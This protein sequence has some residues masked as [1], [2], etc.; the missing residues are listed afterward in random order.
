MSMIFSAEFVR[1]MGPVAREILG[2]PTEEN[3]AKCELRYGTRGSL[4]IDLKKGTFFDNETGDGGG[5]LKFVQVQKHLD[6]DGALAWLQEHRHIT[7]TESERQ[8]AAYDYQAA[9]G[10]LLFQVV[11]F[12]PKDFRQRRPDGNNGWIWKMADVEKVLYRLPVVIA[13]V[14]E[15]RAIYIVEGE[16]AIHALES[17]GLVATCSPGGAGKW[18]GGG[19]LAVPAR[20]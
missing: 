4:C 13:A 14:A 18:R 7:K 5:V 12:E 10:E 2:E 17:F 11:R 20:A 9:T 3:K 8:V 16:K 1:A 15:S 6:K 19:I